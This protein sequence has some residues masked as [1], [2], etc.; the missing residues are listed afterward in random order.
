[1]ISNAVW[2]NSANSFAETDIAD[3][4]TASRTDPIAT[5]GYIASPFLSS[6]NYF[7]S[8]DCK[9]EII[10]SNIQLHLITVNLT[11]QRD[12]LE[13]HNTLR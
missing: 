6:G 9:F 3:I 12:C 13:I 4:C 8:L 5:E 2:K 11:D 10:G 7:E 1:M